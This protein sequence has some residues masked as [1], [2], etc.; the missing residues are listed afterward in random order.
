MK[1]S[2]EVPEQKRI[3]LIIDTDAKNEAD[4]QFA[5]AHALLTPKFDIRG[6]IAAHF[7][8]RRTQHSMRE[9]REEI[10][11]LLELMHMTGSVPVFDGAERALES[12]APPKV[13]TSGVERILEEAW[14]QDARPLFVVFLGP[15]TN[16]AEAWLADPSIAGRLT[17][18]WIGGG[19]WPHGEREFNLEN[20]VLAAN[21]VFKSGIPLWQVPRDV[22]A[23]FRV[24]LAELEDKVQPCGALGEYLFRQM[25]EVNRQNADNRRW[26]HG[27]SWSLG[28]S[29]A[30]TL[31][32]DP[33][34]YSYDWEPA[35]L[36]TR[37]M[38]Y[39]HGQRNRP[40]RVYREVDVRFTL[41]DMYAKFRRF[42]RQA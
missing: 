10:L 1:P 28:D 17:A 11:H 39:V 25:L 32:M 33:H 20:D 14:A 41:E 22:Y 3:R 5:I 6:V 19:A 26:P 15:L 38:S 9:S 36:I 30:I 8:T 34:E 23:T 37:E 29:P 35:P 4:D 21:V 31:L 42:A 24:S 18:I 27:E 16:L 2:Y 7:G 13:L 40:I 12:E